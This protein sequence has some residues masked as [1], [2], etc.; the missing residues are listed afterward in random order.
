MTEHTDKAADKSDKAVPGKRGGRSRTPK[1]K[2][3]QAPGGSPRPEAD[4]AGGAA[5]AGT[6]KSGLT[7]S[8]PAVPG[9]AAPRNPLAP[10][11]ATITFGSNRPIVAAPPKLPESSGLR[12]SGPSAGILKASGPQPTSPKASGLT[13]T[14]AK[15]GT[16][17]KAG[18]KPATAKP[19]PAKPAAKSGNGK[20]PAGDAKKPDANKADGKPAAAKAATTKPGTVKPAIAPQQSGRMFDKERSPAGSLIAVLAALV[21]IGSALSFWLKLD[22]ETAPR[23]ST[24]ALETPA[25][26]APAVSATP[27]SA[28]LA[29]VRAPET[30]GPLAGDPAGGSGAADDALSAAEIEEIQA[31]LSRL[32]LDPGSR[33]GVLTAETTAAIRSYQEMAGL[34]ADGAAD[35]ALLDELRTVAELYGG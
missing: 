8:A 34:P 26:A 3:A 23:E 19:A 35:K 30:P 6:D 2:R 29:S 13:F 11:P 27:D 14:S 9:P 16:A 18:A 31:L 22:N 20:A 4:S 32:D 15:T 12:F 17:A 1:G 7:A 21:V 25:P 10:D 28:P 33:S 24:A 5:A